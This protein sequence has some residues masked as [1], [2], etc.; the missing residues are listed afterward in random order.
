[1]MYCQIKQILWRDGLLTKRIELDIHYLF[2]FI[3]VG[4]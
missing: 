1:M 3:R 4:S 2:R